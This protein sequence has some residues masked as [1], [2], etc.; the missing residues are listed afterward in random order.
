MKDRKFII[1]FMVLI[2]INII[3]FLILN[4]VSFEKKVKK[5]DTYTKKDISKD[6]ILKLQKIDAKLQNVEPAKPIK[7]K[8]IVIVKEI[9]QKPKIV[10]ISKN[11]KNIQQEKKDKKPL[12]LI[13]SQVIQ[14]NADYKSIKKENIYQ[15]LEKKFAS[16]YSYDIALKLAR[17]Y[18]LKK[19]YKK[20]L[21]WAK[22]ANELN[23]KDDKSWI[24]FAKIKIKQGDITE[25][26]RALE[27]YQ[28]S[29]YSKEIE[30]ILKGL[31]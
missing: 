11:S 23:T 31:S 29:Y 26:K 25:A 9:K 6:F 15:K 27:I 28:K 22:I 19:Q 8:K 17:L 10:Y 1:Q 4:F 12:I 13:T 2:F 24:I 20:A 14:K 18:Y 16:S 5:K 3:L 7:P 21:K 30:K